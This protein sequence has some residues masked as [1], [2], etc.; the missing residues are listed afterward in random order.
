MTTLASEMYLHCSWCPLTFEEERGTW[1][2]P[3]CECDIHVNPAGDCCVCDGTGDFHGTWC[4]ACSGTGLLQAH[5]ELLRWPAR[6]LRSGTRREECVP[7][8]VVQDLL[9][10]WIR[11]YELTNPPPG[12]RGDHALKVCAATVRMEIEPVR[13]LYKG[14]YGRSPEDGLVSFRMFDRIATRLELLHEA[15]SDYPHL[16]IPTEIEVA[17]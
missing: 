13:K 14:I 15:R 4:D 1:N 12:R 9:K 6:I 10:R 11:R 16:F 5:Y 8:Y 17:A 3:S 7:A 2:C